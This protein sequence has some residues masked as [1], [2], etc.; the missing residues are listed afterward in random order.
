MVLL[1]LFHIVKKLFSFLKMLK[2][3]SG[4]LICIILNRDFTIC[5][6]EVLFQ[7]DEL[8]MRLEDGESKELIRKLTKIDTAMQRLDLKPPEGPSPDAKKQVDYGIYDAPYGKTSRRRFLKGT[9]NLL[10]Y[11]KSNPDKWDANGTGDDEI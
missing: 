4:V 7:R 11:A 2:R 5:F 8:E 6:Q 10:S 3:W 1:L 9:V